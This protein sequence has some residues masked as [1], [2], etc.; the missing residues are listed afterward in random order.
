M[1]RSFRCVGLVVQ[2][3]HNNMVA[4]NFGIWRERWEGMAR[5]WREGGDGGRPCRG[6]GRGPLSGRGSGRGAIDNPG[7]K[8]SGRGPGKD[9]AAGRG[10]GRGTKGT[11]LAGEW[12]GAK[13]PGRDL[14]RIRPRFPLPDLQSG[15]SVQ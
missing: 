15:F 12:Q 10:S 11:I 4:N 14:A 9:R 8:N 13:N 1:H 6:T 5:F 7:D 2:H 3:P